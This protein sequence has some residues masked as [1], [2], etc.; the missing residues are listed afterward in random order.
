ML[1]LLD[2]TGV[3]ALAVPGCQ[4]LSRWRMSARVRG[5][6]VRSALGPCRRVVWR[7]GPCSDR[8]F[9]N[10]ESHDFFMA[11]GRRAMEG[12]LLVGTGRTQRRL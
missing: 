5:V 8:T 12:G 9:L 1:A 4:V 6:G 11:A 2:V 3:A 7:V 10:Q